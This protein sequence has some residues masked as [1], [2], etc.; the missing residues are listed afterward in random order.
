[1]RTETPL[2]I[3][4]FNRR[5]KVSPQGLTAKILEQT[6]GSAPDALAKR[7]LALGAEPL[8]IPGFALGMAFTALPGIPVRLLFNETDDS[9]PAAASFLYMDTAIRYLNLKDL[10]STCTWLTGMLIR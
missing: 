10:M 6:F 2:I 7:C 3:P 4:F 9:M 1:M 5:I 8:E